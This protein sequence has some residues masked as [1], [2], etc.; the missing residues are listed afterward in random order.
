MMKNA[1]ESQ[2][3]SS[4]FVLASVIKCIFPLTV[5]SLFSVHIDSSVGYSKR[6]KQLALLKEKV[7]F[8]NIHLL[9]LHLQLQVRFDSTRAYETHWSCSYLMLQKK[10]IQ[11]K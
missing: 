2:I 7:C 5:S 6:K 1:T 8:V 4:F 9:Q 3:P 10:M 11:S